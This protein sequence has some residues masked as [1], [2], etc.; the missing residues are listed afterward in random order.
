MPLDITTQEDQLLL[1][2]R[3]LEC[4]RTLRFG[5]DVAASIQHL[6][7]IVGEFHDANRA[8]IFEYDRPAGLV[9]N[10]YEW[11]REGVTQEIDNLQ[12]IPLEVV[13]RWEDLFDE[14]G[15]VSITILDSEVDKES[16]E[17]QILADQ[18]IQSLMVAPIQI[19]DERVGF[20]GVD[21]PREFARSV[22][23]LQ[24]VADLIGDDIQKR[25]LLRTATLE[26]NNLIEML[27][28]IS[29][30]IVVGKFEGTA[31]AFTSVNQYFCDMLGMTADEILGRR[32]SGDLDDGR[33]TPG[34]LE[35]I[36]PDDINIV[37]G[38][39][40][41][42]CEGKG[43]EDQA[44]FRLK[45]LAKPEGQYF[46]CRSRTV[47]QE[48]GTYRVYSV[49]MD[50]TAQQAQK[51]EFDRVMQDLLVT[52]PHSRC[53]YRL[54]LTRNLCSDCH[55]ATEFT[56]H[57]VDASTADELLARAADIII[58]EDMKAEFKSKYSR[59]GMIDLFLSGEEKFSLTYRRRTD[60]DR[61]LWVQTF[62]HLLRNPSNNE[63][64]AIAYTMDIDRQM[65]EDLV[66]STIAQKEFYAYGVVD[67]KNNLAEHYYRAGERVEEEPSDLTTDEGFASVVSHLDGDE[68]DF[69]QS[70][71]VDHVVEQLATEETFTHRFSMDGR[72]MQ[73]NYRYLDDRHDYLS[74][75]ISDV[76]EAVAREEKVAGV[77]REALTAAEGANQAK[78]EFLSRMSHDIRTPMNAIIG[79]STL[80][81]RD[82]SDPARVE[83]EA[84]KIL[85][86]SNHLLGLINDVLDMS[87]IESGAVQ[88]NVHEFALSK[89]IQMVDRIMRPQMEE[90]SQEFDLYVKGVRHEMFV[91]DDQRLQQVLINVL[92]NA[93]KY[94][95]D[96]GRITLKVSS[97]PQQSGKYESVTFE[98]TDNGRGM[99][100]EYQKVIFEPFSREQLKTQ[101][102]A[103]GT[104]LGM[105]ITRN[106]VNMM[107]G[108]ISVASTLGEGSTFTIVLPLLLPDR[109]EDREFWKTH[110]LTHMLVVDDDPDICDNVV[111]AMEDVGVRMDLALG[112]EDAVR[113]V[114][115]SLDQGDEFDLVLLD[116][117]MP[118]MDG[119]QTTRAIREICP[120]DVLIIIL[121]AYDYTAIEEEAREAGVDGFISK[122]FFVQ[123]LQKAVSDI[124]D[125][126]EKDEPGA[127]ADGTSLKGLNIL[128]AE[129][130]LL[131]AELLSE[132]IKL[133]EATVTI[134][135]NGEKVFERFATEPAGAYDLILMDIQMPVMNGYE[136]TR[137]IRALAESAE[138]DDAKR[139]EAT[140]IPIVAMT[141]N[142]FSDDVQE[143]L[144]S[145]MNAHLAKPLDLAAL[146]TT[147]AQVMSER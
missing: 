104:G 99:T 21:D 24:S 29:A 37:F 86:S 35:A 77:L 20:I 121:T 146:R 125:T 51:A 140:H 79:F 80:L 47:L 19:D 96:G 65:K 123:G 7:Q 101:E 89:T 9:S 92:S 57:I 30:G 138:V 72:R 119:V 147:V 87:K 137:A 16:E 143:A 39:F 4:I 60:G 67:I 49:Y 36:H 91:G 102:V 81:L 45:T 132:V 127:E 93:T 64:E 142:A 126:D 69:R 56:R 136:A 83:D 129:D 120:R 75:V 131:N 26:A 94:T 116:W 54:N 11:C 40:M 5:S 124:Q 117:K 53:S 144:L 82:A 18:G 14:G 12:N 112:G 62:Y 61:Y 13:A 23:L 10:T 88:M 118:D 27:D 133:H 48:D 78:S 122:P 111:E 139:D 106:L 22:T 32:E 110:S 66:F 105:A 8:Y 145:G 73:L 34:L 130:N 44:T 63:I 25:H 114:R 128:A 3:L 135:P 17:Y 98:V 95:D 103:Q 74:F 70:I 85:A 50:A 33:T 41:G 84:E 1:Q 71:N 90:R 2:G 15:N 134:E 6:L 108:T 31:G 115:R 76:T 28:T 68:A 52:N 58:D 46:L 100:E 38:Y 141:A 59:Q 107:G 55:G 43:R 97:M 109:D 113:L 42:L